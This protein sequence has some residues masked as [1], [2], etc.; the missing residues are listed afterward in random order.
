MVSLAR[1]F[2]S[3]TMTGMSGTHSDTCKLSS[4]FFV[5]TVDHVAARGQ[6]ACSLRREP[7]MILN[8]EDENKSETWPLSSCCN[9]SAAADTGRNRSW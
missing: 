1:S 9:D 6:H 8:T 7:S 4:L 3:V 2:S 5:T